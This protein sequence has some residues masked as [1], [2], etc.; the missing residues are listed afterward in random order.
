MLTKYLLLS[1]LITSQS[2]W[3][4]KSHD[5]ILQEFLKQRQKMMEEMM[6]AFDDDDFFK[7]ND[8]GG[9]KVFQQLK[10]HGIGGFGSFKTEGQNVSVEEKIKKDGSIDIIIT[11]KNE[12][13]NLNIETK[14]NRITIKSEMR[15]DEESENAGNVSRSLRSSSFSR[16]VSIP[17][18]YIAQDPKQVEKSIVIT[19][20]PEGKKNLLKKKN[21]REPIKRKK[22]EK[23]I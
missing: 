21:G 2:L 19:L 20:I 12:N 5:E 1:L 13:I 10:K 4:Q 7:D 23:V 15:V 22:D 18:G 11:P 9:D 3:A 14:N 6:R 17:I 16:S 8:F